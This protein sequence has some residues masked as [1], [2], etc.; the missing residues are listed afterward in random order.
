MFIIAHNG[1]RIWGGAE[2]ATAL[3]LAGLRGRGHRVLLFC[4]DR[5]VAEHAS[6]M[7]VPTE[8]VPLG[9]DLALPHAARMAA[10]LRRHRPDAFVIGTFRKLFLAAFAAHIAGVPRVVA[11]VGLE[12]DRPRSAKYRA[13]LPRWVDA[14]VVNASKMRPAFLSLSGYSEARVPVI[15]NGVLPPARRLPPG[16]VRALLGIAPGAPVVGAVG[17]LAEQKHYH[18]LLRAAAGLSPDVHCVLAGDGDERGALE[19][20][21]RELGIAD[22]AHFLGY[23]DDPGDVL[24]ALDVFVV[25]SNREGLSNA[26]LEALAAGVPVV[27]TPVS[28][29]DDAL[30]PLPDGR[31]PG[32]IVGHE[33]AEIAAALRE[34]LGGRERLREMGGAA[35]ERAETAFSMDGMLD[36]WEA[37]LSADGGSGR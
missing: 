33:P 28:G 20:L 30:A 22:R 29:A 12:T 5:L 37:V 31:R 6:A 27:S 24:A 1:A 4:N 3:L 26:M 21:A 32:V 7:G 17:R 14:V 35:R 18:R 34:L 8:I 11:R 23:R 16:A 36:A 13:A 2:K 10:A 19:A 15:H 9:G 25:C